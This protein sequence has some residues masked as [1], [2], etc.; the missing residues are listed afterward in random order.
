MDIELDDLLNRLRILEDEFEQKVEA[1]R[2][3]F[4]YRLRDR[5]VKF[6]KM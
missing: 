4:R 1:Q 3:A 6:E 2:A 5:R